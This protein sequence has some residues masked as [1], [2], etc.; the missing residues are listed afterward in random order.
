[1]RPTNTD[2]W[3]GPPRGL[4][5]ARRAETHLRRD[6][7]RAFAVADIFTGPISREETVMREKVRMLL[8]DDDESLV[9]LLTPLISKFFAE[10]VALTEMT[11][12]VAAKHWIGENAPDLVLTD[13][14][15]PTVDGFEILRCAKRQNPYCQVIIHSGHF[16]AEALRLALKLEAA[17]YLPKSAGPDD[18]LH[19]LE[20]A[21]RRNIRWMQALPVDTACL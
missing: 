16:S 11:D 6:G 4:A 15:M 12:P 14:Q 5:G 7:S 8:V 3:A 17:D 2:E 10:R 21:Y 1:M 9:L 20:Y 13:L 19:S 18:L